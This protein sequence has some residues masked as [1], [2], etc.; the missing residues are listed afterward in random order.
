MLAEIQTVLTMMLQGLLRLWPYLLLTIPLAV[1]VNLS[2]AARYIRKAFAARPI[3]AIVLA[4]IVGA[5]SPFCACEVIPVIAS[6]LLGGVPL[7]PVMSFWVAS[8]SMDPEIFLLSVAALG[9]KL[10]VWR[11][12]S[13]LALSLGAGLITH[14]A[15]QRGWLTEPIM[16]TR[17]LDSGAQWSPISAVRGLLQRLRAGVRPAAPALAVGTCCGGDNPR[18]VSG[19]DRMPI[20]R[21][22]LSIASRPVASTGCSQGCQVPGSAATAEQCSEERCSGPQQPFARRLLDESTSAA[23]MVGKFMLLALL[24]EA[25]FASFVPREWVVAVAGSGSR[26]AVLWAAM[27]GVPLYTTNLTAVPLI[28]ALLGQ[29][30]N[31]SAALAFLIAGPTTTIPSMAAVWGLVNRRVFVLYVGFSLVGAVLFGLLHQLVNSL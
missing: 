20:A 12:A 7:A 26:L 18:A 3:P 16:R 15:V 31:P 9:W 14:L 10:A 2:G 25:L 24:L 19:P 1:A 8:P 17:T 13:T 11:L 5:F 23:L 4:T 22:A 21:P 6:L 28:G 30:M 29:G 27:V